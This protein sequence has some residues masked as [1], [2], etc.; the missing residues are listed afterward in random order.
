LFFTLRIK[1]D[2]ASLDNK[3]MERNGGY[4]CSYF[5]WLF[6]VSSDGK[7]EGG[8]GVGTGVRGEVLSVRQEMIVIVLKGTGRKQLAYIPTRCHMND[9]MPDMQRYKIGAT[10]KMIVQ[11]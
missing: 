11:V 5:S 8:L 1:L 7:L 9:L 4:I 6:I 3:D 10:S 2:H